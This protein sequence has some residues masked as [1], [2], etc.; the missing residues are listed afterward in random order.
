MRSTEQV[1]LIGKLASSEHTSTAEK[2][3]RILSHAPHWKKY[4]LA[5][6]L[7][8]GSS[9]KLMALHNQSLLV[10]SQLLSSDKQLRQLVLNCLGITPDLEPAQY[11]LTMIYELVRDD[12][13]QYHG[14]VE[15]TRG[16]PIFEKFMQFLERP[17][18]DSY[19]SDKLLFFL[20]GLI[21][22]S[23]DGAY[24]KENITE[25]IDHLFKTPENRR[26][27]SGASQDDSSL[28]SVTSSS[29]VNKMESSYSTLN[30]GYCSV[31]GALDVL[32]NLV[33]VDSYRMLVLSHPNV[34]EFISSNLSS[35]SPTSHIYKACV[36]VW[37]LSFNEETVPILVSR[38]LIRQIANT[39]IDCR[40]EKVVR[41]TLNLLKNVM[42][43]DAAI[44]SIIDLGLLQYLTILEYEKWLDPEIYEEI[45]QGQIM[46]DQK[47]KQFSNFDRYCIELEKK[48]FKWSFLHTEKF[49]LEN[50][51]N[52]ETDEFAAIKKLAHLLK[53]SDDPVTLAVACFDIGEFARLYPM[54][55]QILGKLNVKEV[56][57]T[58][59]TSPNREISKEALLSIQKIMLN[60]WNRANIASN[61]GQNTTT[62]IKS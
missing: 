33:K 23:N 53:T 57:M 9:I 52:F 32:G 7:P 51:M 28:F 2:R 10:R 18:V 30:G 21:S 26:S 6:A 27:L 19:L 35:S 31:I 3:S 48:K 56:L 15:T 13:G 42:N 16:I 36:V 46:I 59:M 8:V 55:K 61:S 54:G 62:A 44:E 45:R 41:V 39:I 60:K 47:L 14:F 58:L 4:E 38:D 29:N 40:S 24:T 43:N 25:L 49:W 17:K 37:L 11:I 1:K 20:S 12:A 50:V 5:G 34:I 22:H